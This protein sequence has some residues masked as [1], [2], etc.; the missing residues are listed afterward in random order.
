MDDVVRERP[1]AVGSGN[2]LRLKTAQQVSEVVVGAM[3]RAGS[4][5]VAVSG[6]A[7]DGVGTR[8]EQR[9]VLGDG[10]DRYRVDLGHGARARS[11]VHVDGV[12]YVTL[13]VRSGPW[14][15]RRGDGDSAVRNPDFGDTVRAKNLVEQFRAMGG[16]RLVEAGPVTVHGVR[17]TRYLLEY[18]ADELMEMV[19]PE[20]VDEQEIA[21]LRADIGD[22]RVRTAI[23]VGADGRPL[24]LQ[25]VQVIGREP[26][27]D[28]PVGRFSGWGTTTVEV[29]PE[30]KVAPAR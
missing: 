29:P 17:G 1:E 9:V 6:R 19:R 15:W 4:Y 28:L 16:G 5:T 7:E 26:T 27:D 18:G 13:A 24:F 22:G 30:G 2:P 10:A 8:V 23:A 12:Y 21:E 3:E 20:T 25:M 11:L 14:E